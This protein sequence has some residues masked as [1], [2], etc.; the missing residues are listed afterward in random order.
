MFNCHKLEF[1]I[2]NLT[3]RLVLSIANSIRIILGLGY[4]TLSTMTLCS[5]YR[6]VLNSKYTLSGIPL[7]ILLLRYL[8]LAEHPPRNIL[9]SYNFASYWCFDLKFRQIIINYPY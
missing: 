9:N 8:M 2:I 1:Y 7:R 6:I 3:F 5:P 4:K